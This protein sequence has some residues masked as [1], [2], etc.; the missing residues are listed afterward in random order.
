MSELYRKTPRRQTVWNI[1]VM[2]MCIIG[3]V[4]I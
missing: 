1:S 4:D 3:G 2:K